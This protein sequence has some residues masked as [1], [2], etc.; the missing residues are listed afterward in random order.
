MPA[1]GTV[2][3]TVYD[4]LGRE[5]R[6]LVDGKKD[7]GMNGVD[8]DASGL[9]SGVY[10]YRLHVTPPA[11]PGAAPGMPGGFTKA[12]AMILLR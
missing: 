12:R 6:L 11:S 4:V 3:L 8:F 1:S 9:P 5:V 10:F 2:R 7:A